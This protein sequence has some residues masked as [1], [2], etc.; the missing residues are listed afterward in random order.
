MPLKITPPRNKKTKNLYIRGA[1]LGF[2]VDKS[3]G[4]DKRRVA[5]TILKRI[6][7]EIQRGEYQRVKTSATR[8]CTNIFER[9]GCLP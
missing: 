1:Y 6:E 2:T 7:G 9:R 8:G 5:E 3:S 4:T